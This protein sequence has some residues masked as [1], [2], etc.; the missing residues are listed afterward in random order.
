[1]NLVAGAVEVA[2]M[3]WF[4]KNQKNDMKLTEQEQMEMMR[5]QINST[6]AEF[7]PM[8]KLQYM[9]QYFEGDSMFDQRAI[10]TVKNEIIKDL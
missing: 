5:G 1:M 7:T 4:C 10:D 8:E 9:K 2:S 6:N 3:Q